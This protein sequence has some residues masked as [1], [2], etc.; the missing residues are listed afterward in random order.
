MPPKTK[1]PKTKPDWTLCSKSGVLFHSADAASHSVWL[2]LPQTSDSPPHPHIVSD[3]FNSFPNLIPSATLAVPLSQKQLFSSVFISPCV[4]KHL[5]LGQAS[6]VLATVK[7]KSL[8]LTVYTS[9]VVPPTKISCTPLSWLAS[10]AGHDSWVSVEQFSSVIETCKELAIVKVSKS[11]RGDDAD[12]DTQSD[13]FYN[14]IRFSLSG[15]I[16]KRECVVPIMYTGLPLI[17]TLRVEMDKPLSLKMEKLALN[18]EPI[19]PKIDQYQLDTS[20]PLNPQVLSTSTPQKVPNHDKDDVIYHCI[21]LNTSLIV[22]KKNHHTVDKHQFVGGLDKEIRILMSSLKQ[23]LNPENT[24][25]RTLTGLLMFGPPGTG[26]SLLGQQLHRLL[27]VRM[28]SITGPELYSKFY[29]ETEAQLRSKFEEAFKASPCI[30]FIDDIDSLAPKRESG[31]SDQERRVLASLLSLLD[32][33]HIQQLRVAVVAATSRVD[34]VNPALRRPGRFDMEIELS[35]PDVAQR[36]SILSGILDDECS[37]SVDQ[38]DIETI[39]R[40]THGFVGADLQALI[41]RASNYANDLGEQLSVKHFNYVRPQVK[42]SAMRE[43]MVEVPQV[44]WDDIGGLEDLKLKLR[45]AVEWPIKNPEIFTR[46]GITAPK[47]L[48]MYG[49][50]GCSKTM[51][52]KALANESGLNFLSI[53]GPELFSKWVGESERAVREVFRKARQVKPSIVFFDEID[54]VGGAR[55][56][57][58]NGGSKVG[59]RVLAQLLTEMDGV[60]GLV[61]VTVVAATNRPDMMDQALLRPGRLDRVVYVPLPD[62]E[63]RL[64]VLLVHT[65]H[66]PLSES[67][68]LNTVACK[69]NGYSGAEVSAIC[70]EAA[71]AA[72]EECDTASEVTDKHFEI[73]LNNVK[74]RISLDLFKVYEKFQAD[75]SSKKV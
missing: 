32:Q 10:V 39:A 71:L 17:L 20:L 43:V 68:N 14:A 15:L 9:T 66:I 28:F 22:S 31:G 44:T 18:E 67:V 21:S 55:G 8:V 12:I 37:H 33:I 59:D 19:S 69:T 61:G 24:V 54:A 46:M 13:K 30:L 48:L 1:S 11:L 29:G 7:D 74:P 52:A 40:E 4:A 58:G 60:E 64:K 5:G 34:G 62:L 3:K 42:P 38:C 73:A 25:K 45:Q 47:G 50:P 72:L 56:S 63:T 70:N 53:K 57:S 27:G 26:K 41:C 23:V 75:Q 49:P 65:K 36:S 16:I 2:G 51:I 35:V 6:L